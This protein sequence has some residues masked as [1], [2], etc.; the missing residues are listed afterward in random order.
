MTPSPQCSSHRHAS[1]W[2][3]ESHKRDMRCDTRTH[4]RRSCSLNMLDTGYTSFG[5]RIDTAIG[6]AR[7][8][9]SNRS[10][11]LLRH[12]SNPATRPRRQY[13]SSSLSFATFALNQIKMCPRFTCFAS[14]KSG[15]MRCSPG[16][17]EKSKPRGKL[18][19]DDYA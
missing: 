11:T 2:K 9:P 18:K 19:I 10:D 5:F 17:R 13:V 6:L 14:S 8:E 4:R 12:L 3:D 7:S 1:K 16:K 15:Q